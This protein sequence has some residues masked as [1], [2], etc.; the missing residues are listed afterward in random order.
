MYY[1]FVVGF[2]VA[3]GHFVI[4][5]CIVIVGLFCGNSRRR[6]LVMRVFVVGVFGIN[7]GGIGLAIFGILRSNAEFFANVYQM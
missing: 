4:V 5:V 2:G 7:L 1:P 6:V 3:F